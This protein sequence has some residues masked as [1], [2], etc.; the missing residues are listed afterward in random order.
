MIAAK[1]QQSA[2]LRYALAPVCIALAVALHLSAVGPFLH[3]TGLFL[4]CIV[5]AAWF[6]GAGPGLFAAL[7]GTLALPLLID[8]NYPLLAGFFDLPRFLTF[9]PTGLAV[10][11]GINPRYGDLDPPQPR[12]GSAASERA[13]PSPGPQG[14]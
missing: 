14:A 3:P 7:L 12:R 9:G 8:M 1:L 10:G 6:G 5:A 4:L 2:A 13:Q 11:C